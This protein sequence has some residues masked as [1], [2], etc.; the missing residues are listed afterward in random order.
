MSR[1]AAA[2]NCATVP[3]AMRAPP[4]ALH[5]PISRNC[6]TRCFPARG[7]LWAPASHSHV[8]AGG[9]ACR[10]SNPRVA[11]GAHR[12]SGFHCKPIAIIAAWSVTSCRSPPLSDNATACA[13]GLPRHGD[14]MAG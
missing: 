7:S 14:I 4:S 11:A 9:S 2:M 8:T 10:G 5:M 1:A 6:D 12:R 13:S 3:G